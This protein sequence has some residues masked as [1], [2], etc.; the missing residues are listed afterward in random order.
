LIERR[1]SG[2]SG[3]PLIFDLIEIQVAI[4]RRSG[5][6]ESPLTPHR[7]AF[8]DLLQQ[9]VQPSSLSQGYLSCLTKVVNRTTKNSGES[10][11]RPGQ[12]NWPWQFFIFALSRI[13]PFDEKRIVHDFFMT[14]SRY[15]KTRARTFV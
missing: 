12:F 5:K 15:V 10:T 9:A 2:V 13:Q 6:I 7:L 1:S 14:D 3:L 11:C 4:E 8:F